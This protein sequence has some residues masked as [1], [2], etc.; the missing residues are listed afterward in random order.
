MRQENNLPYT[1]LDQD[2]RIIKTEE[3]AKRGIRKAVWISALVLAALGALALFFP[4][5]VSTGFAFLIT[6]GVFLYGL[7]QGIT[8][9]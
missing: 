8:Y 3:S 7:S 5:A 1:V 6:A 2:G 4:V 9:F